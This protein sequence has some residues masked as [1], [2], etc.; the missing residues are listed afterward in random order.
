MPVNFLCS[1]IRFGKF[2]LNLQT[3]ELRRQGDKIKLQEQPFQVLRALLERPG[4]LVTREELRSKLWPADTF[5]DFDHSLNVAIKRLREAL[6]ESADS[7]VFIETLA[8]RG[9]R[10]IAPV[11][12]PVVSDGIGTAP[13][14]KRSQLS[15]V[16]RRIGIACLASIV[17]VA[18]LVSAI[19]WHP[20]S[21]ANAR[22]Q[23]LTSNSSENSVSSATI[24]PDGKYLA[25]ADR[26]GLYLKLIRTGETHAVTLPPDFSAHVDD[27]FPDGSHVLVSR[28]DPLGKTS[29]WNISI[30]G[31]SPRL[32][33]DDAS[34]GSASPDG[35][36]VAFHR[37]DLTYEGWFG[38][39]VWIMR[40]DGTDAIKVASDSHSLMGT[41]T[42]SPDGKRI[43]YVKTALAYNSPWSLIEVNEWERAKTEPL[44]SDHRL[45]P[46]LEWLSDGRLIYGV[47]TEQGRGDS[48]LFA[49]TILPSGK[50]SRAP[51]RIA[52]G[53]GG[54]TQVSGS[55]D[56]K[57]LA[58]LRE[59]WSPSIYLG[60]LTAD[61]TS[62][63]THRRLTLDENASIP[64]A[65]TPDSN[66]V[67]F[68]SDR[69]GTSEI[70]KQNTDQSIAETLVTSIEQLSQ[71]RLSPDG[72]EMLYVSTPK[73]TSSET[74]S[75]IL[76]TPVAGGTPRLVLRD[77]GI[78]A[79]EC[80]RSPSTICLYSISKGN[81]RQ[82]FHFDL[83]T[84]KI[85]GAPQVDSEGFW[86]LSPDGSQRAFVAVG[87]NQG[88]I[89]LRS[90]S[91]E[92]SRDLVVQ[93]W[94][95]LMHIDWSADGRSLLVGYHHQQQESALL[96]ITLDGKVSVLLRS[97][98][99][100]GYAIPS[101][102]GRLLAILEVRPTKNAWQ[103][104]DF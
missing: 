20:S 84:G 59:H 32:L 87:S 10:F 16:I 88:T 66:A 30:F 55:A 2:E 17:I 37:A 38:R 78:Y 46:G 49:A 62:L 82:T 79:V 83:R 101:P 24:S 1:I 47:N 103:I 65:W 52:Q 71:P 11:S 39:E 75:S 95:G 19:K 18:A 23:K 42:W 72:S 92:E 34:G 73:S 67:L 33:A 28:T 74:P 9:Y 50:L 94:N 27:W 40:S 53:S 43:A 21:G 104:V 100:I 89:Q 81:R 77:V 60:T 93:G 13:S 3:G 51:K 4:E 35:A 44:Y 5:V 85:Q 45:V 12:S 69:N 54:I 14:R 86:S 96:R 36:R 64:T 57:V 31:G 56:G 68:S 58:C 29:L 22:E 8:R 6:G 61:G 25:Y 70:F 99:F 91:S 97:S 15:F 98:D 90:T 48:S 41:P 26:T 7:P 102:D 76:A 63:R 80:A